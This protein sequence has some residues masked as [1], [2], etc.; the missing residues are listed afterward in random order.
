MSRRTSVLG[1]GG[2]GEA[3]NSRAEKVNEARKAALEVAVA[4]GG[5]RQPIVSSS[6]VVSGNAGFGAGQEHGDPLKSGDVAAPGAGAAAA[7]R[8]SVGFVED[9]AD[10]ASTTSQA[11]VTSAALAVQ[12]G[13]MRAAAAGADHQEQRS[14]LSVDSHI[15]L[16]LTSV[17]DTTITTK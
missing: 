15:D 5:G 8:R 4:F 7:G 9:F 17:A 10:N 13:A 11:S 6:P 2:D 14:D 1:R 16:D 12:R 3:S